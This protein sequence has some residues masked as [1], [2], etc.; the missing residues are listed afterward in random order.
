MSRVLA[1][2]WAEYNVRVNC[3]SPTV[4]L[5]E[6]GKVAWSG[7]EGDEMKRKIPLGRFGQP[8]DVAAGVVFLA[9]TGANMITGQNLV[10]DGGYT[11]Q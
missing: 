3:I 8:E 2:E 4:I 1:F 6:L 11:I 7:K 5:T 10:I 9:S